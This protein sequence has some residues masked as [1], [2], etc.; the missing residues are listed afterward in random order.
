VLAALEAKKN[1]AVE[2]L[3]L[4]SEA[5][6]LVEAYMHQRQAIQTLSHELQNASPAIAVVKEGAVAENMSAVTADLANL[7]AMQNRYRSDLAPLCEGCLAEK[8]AKA[9]TEALRETT[10]AA[11]DQ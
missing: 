7:R 11:L 9:Q 10:R 4:P 5:E 8:A 1:A 2:P 3:A 6:P